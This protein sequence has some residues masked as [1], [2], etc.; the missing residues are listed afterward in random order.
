MFIQA[1][2]FGNIY[3]YIKYYDGFDRQQLDLI[4]PVHFK[5]A[6]NLCAIK[7]LCGTCITIHENSRQIKKKHLSR[8]RKL[9]RR[10]T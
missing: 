10:E 2:V 7:F 3:I 6:V 8:G 9:F 1:K 5:Y 4:G